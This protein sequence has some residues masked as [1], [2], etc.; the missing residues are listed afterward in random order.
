MTK[1]YT[2]Q[3]LLSFFNTGDDQKTGAKQFNELVRYDFLKDKSYDDQRVL[4]ESFQQMTN[5]FA[6]AF[7]E[8]LET[9]KRAQKFVYNREQ[10]VGFL[11][12]LG[13][14][15][16]RSCAQ[17]VLHG[18]CDTD[19]APLF[20]DEIQYSVY[21]GTCDTIPP[22]DE[23]FRKEFSEIFE[24][25]EKAAS[26]YCESPSFAVNLKNL[27][28][29]LNNGDESVSIQDGLALAMG[30]ESDYWYFLLTK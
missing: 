5:S 27:V 23:L 15:V 29:L 12:K 17:M 9:N 19:N 6:L 1:E 8:T 30:D 2:A 4:V 14:E 21:N 24:S 3:W 20:L 11:T 18:F 7:Q 13:C 10:I 25:L 26:P 22:Y 16:K 28:T